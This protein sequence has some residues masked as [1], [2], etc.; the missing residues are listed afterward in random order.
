MIDLEEF[1]RERQDRIRGRAE[2][3]LEKVVDRL[4]RID[5]EGACLLGV[6]T[7]SNS[8]LVATVCFLVWVATRS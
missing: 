8:A 1:I 3:R 4:K 6:M 5:W 7:A 2:T